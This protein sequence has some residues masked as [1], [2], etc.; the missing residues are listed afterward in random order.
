MEPLTDTPTA[1]APGEERARPDRLWNRGFFLLWQGQMISQFGTLATSF[2]MTLWL[3]DAT[4]SASL[5]GLL[6]AALLLPSVVLG[7]I[8]GTFADR[9]SRIRIAVVCDVLSGAG[10]L[11]LA[12]FMF[13]PR[14][15]SQEPGAV[16]FAIGLMFAVSVLAGTLRAFF[17]PALTAVIPDLVPQDKIPAAN[18]LNQFAVQGSTLLGQSIGAWLYQILGAPVVFLIDGVSFIYAGICAAFIRV[19]PKPQKPAAE[20]AFRGFLAETGEGFRYIWR[21]AGLRDFIGIASLVNFFGMPIAVLLPFYV[22]LYLKLE[23]KWYGFLMAAISLGSVAG[24]IFAGTLSLEGRSRQRGIFAAMVLAPAFFGVLGFV[25]QAYVAMGLMFLGGAALG[26]I[27][28]YVLT[29][30]Q[31]ATADE[32][33]GRVMGVVLTVTGSLIPLG[34]VVGGIVGD[35]TGK[36]I[37]LVYGVCGAAALLV[38]LLGLRRNLREFLANG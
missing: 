10:M 11:A 23:S 9:H 8:G 15:A 33:R 28:V 34:M 30:I 6:T 18:S 36:N 27:N 38:S 35:L 25:T 20:Q 5:M 7:P 12:L 2:A 37:P 1:A 3:K 22:E 29:M 14:V 13:D 26:F 17:T 19:P 4:G 21:Q 24:Y 31:V 16:R 32:M